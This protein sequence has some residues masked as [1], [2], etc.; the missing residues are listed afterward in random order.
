MKIWFLCFLPVGEL[1]L[2]RK[3]LNEIALGFFLE[4]K[5]MICNQLLFKNNLSLKFVVQDCKNEEI[6]KLQLLSVLYS[7]GAL[8]V[9][10][11]ES[12]EVVN[13]FPTFEVQNKPIVSIT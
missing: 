11:S 10:G 12:Y 4:K 7:D 5:Q 8:V 6:E 9:G 2:I 1:L 3:A 13:T